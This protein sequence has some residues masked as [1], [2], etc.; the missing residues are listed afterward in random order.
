MLTHYPLSRL[1]A[2]LSPLDEEERTFV[3][4]PLSHVDF[5]L[6]NRLT[7]K[8][9][10]ALEVD[11]W[12]YH[13]GSTTQRYRDGLKDQ[14]LTK[15]AL[16]PLRLSTTD[17]VTAETLAETLSTRL[18]VLSSPSTSAEGTLQCDGDRATVVSAPSV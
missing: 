8:P 9:L 18:R 1:L 11:G 5:L 17:Y 7:R 13:Q 12:S 2:D 16:T 6:Y 10:I 4:S 14:I 3:Q 15:Y